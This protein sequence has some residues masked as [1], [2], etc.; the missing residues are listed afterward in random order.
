M[1]PVVDTVVN[2]MTEVPAF[3]VPADPETVDSYWRIVEEGTR[4]SLELLDRLADPVLVTAVKNA[5]GA[6]FTVEVAVADYGRGASG[7]AAALLIVEAIGGVGGAAATLYQGARI[8]VAAYRAVRRRLGHRPFVSVGAAKLLAA[9]DLLERTGFDDFVL[10]GA[11]DVADSPHDEAFT[12]A[13]QFWVVFGR[14]PD[15]FVYIVDGAGRCHYMG[16]VTLYRDG[17]LDMLEGPDGRKAIPLP[18]DEED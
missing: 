10:V 9:A 2:R 3:Q 17:W 12:G 6:S 7:V 4:P 16:V 13:D 1:S 15:L 18:D 5:I 11:G 8:S 14:F